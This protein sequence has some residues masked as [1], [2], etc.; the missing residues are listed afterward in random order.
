[1]TDRRYDSSLLIFERV[2][3]TAEEMQ[4]LLFLIPGCRTF[5]RKPA[6]VKNPILSVIERVVL[7]VEYPIML[8]NVLM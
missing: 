8:L 3:H 2:T 6:P 1:M 5:I 7:V 4:D